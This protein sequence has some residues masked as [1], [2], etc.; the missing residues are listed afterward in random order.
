MWH[1][2]ERPASG[3]PLTSE[4]GGTA[5]IGR[6]VVIK[7]EVTSAADLT[8]EGRIEGRI[9]LQGHSLVVGCGGGIQAEIVAKTVVIQGAVTGNVTAR[10]KVDIRE[11]G[12]IEGDIVAPRVAIADGAI[13]R[14][15]VETQRESA[16][17]PRLPLA[18]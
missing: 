7:G 16:E 8:V 14:G 2:D 6:A 10:E 4:E 3:S 11:T 1:A 18:V 5:C 13:L 12:S 9:D 17:R 15:R